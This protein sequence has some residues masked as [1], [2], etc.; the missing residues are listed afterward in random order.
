M[1]ICSVAQLEDFKKTSIWEAIVAELNT[2]I[3][4]LHQVLEDPDCNQSV[5]FI[6]MTQGGIRSFKEVRDN[7]L[8]VLIGLSSE[9]REDRNAE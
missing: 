4:Y 6:R 2:R 5:D 9:E 7:L 8:D 1:L 3:D